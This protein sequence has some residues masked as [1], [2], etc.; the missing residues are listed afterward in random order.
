[1]M[2]PVQTR[3]GGNIFWKGQE[4]MSRGVMETFLGCRDHSRDRSRK[5]GMEMKMVSARPEHLVADVSRKGV[6]Y[7]TRLCSTEMEP[8]HLIPIAI[9]VTVIVMS[10]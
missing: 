4:L 10:S 6:V 8:I 9:V 7:D 2:H 3:V 5:A 1:M